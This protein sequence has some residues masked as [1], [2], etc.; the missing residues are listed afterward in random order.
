[1]NKRLFL[2]FLIVLAQLGYLGYGYFARTA[3]IAQSPHIKI[4]VEPYDPRDFFRGDYMTLN[5]TV[6]LPLPLDPNDSRIG[7]SLYWGEA[8]RDYAAKDSYG[9]GENI[10]EQP[11]REPQ[12]NEAVEIEPYTCEEEKKQMAVFFLPDE[13]NI[14]RF[15]RVEKRGSTEDVCRGAEIRFDME[16]ECLWLSQKTLELRLPKPLRY[17]IPEHTGNLLPR[18]TPLVMEIA[19]RPDGTLLLVELYTEDGTPF[20][21]AVRAYQRTA[22]QNSAAQSTSV[23]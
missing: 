5:C 2:L 15:A 22:E 11:I 6:K 23:K 3:E 14:Y 4:A 8:L 21:E 18:Q 20:N 12:M 17:Y 13:K 19:R 16:L 10:I 7:K 9:D 1:M